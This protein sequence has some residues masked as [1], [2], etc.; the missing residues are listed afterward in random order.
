ME[1][2][3]AEQLTEL[4]RVFGLFAKPAPGASEPTLTA[5]ALAAV[6][7]GM[8]VA[9]ISEA[10]AADH[11]AIADASGRGR[12]RFDDFAALATQPFAD[13]DTDVE[14]DA[15]FGAMDADADGV[16]SA[17]DL[18]AFV[19]AVTGDGAG[20]FAEV[21]ARRRLRHAELAAALTAAD[22]EELVREGG[23]ADRGATT[24]GGAARPGGDRPGLSRAQLEELLEFQM[25]P[26][27]AAGESGGA[28][29]S[30]SG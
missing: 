16:V 15:L 19:A 12:L 14:Y 26:A 10:T 21:E 17:A 4:R 13:T 5:S 11:I 20:A 24:V 25:P 7:A 8:G 2:L 23:G 6:L 1:H 3:S 27:A 30:A 18:A 28:G 9:A 29:G 22:A